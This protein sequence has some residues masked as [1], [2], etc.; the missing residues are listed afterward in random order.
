MHKIE[1]LVEVLDIDMLK[2]S[3]DNG[4][5]AIYIDDIANKFCKEQIKEFIEYAH[6]NDVKVYIA[7]N[8][9]PHEKDLD[10]FENDLKEL[11]KFKVDA[12]VVIDPSTLRLVKN[13]IPSVEIHMS[14]QANITNYVTAKFWHEQGVKRV[15]ASKELSCNEIKQIRDNTS[16][17]MDI[18]AIVQGSLGISYSGRNLLSNFI[19]DKSEQKL[20]QD[21]KYNLVEQKRPGQYFPVYQDERGTFLFNTEDISMLEHIPQ[22]IES[23]ITSLKISSR[24]KSLEYVVESTKLYRQAIDMFYENPNEWKANPKWLESLYSID[25]RKTTSGF[26]IE[27]IEDNE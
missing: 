16:N 13:T 10:I 23:G 21:K 26:Y 17:K 3:V 11:E 12:I 1:L 22:L 18:E 8:K 4:A 9:I 24:L 15:V 7:F 5:D 6:K 19:T 27:Q 20:V 2:A 14:D 25:K